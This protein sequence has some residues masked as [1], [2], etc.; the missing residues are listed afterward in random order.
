MNREMGEHV[1]EKSDTRG[2][3]M[4]ASSI[5]I[6]VYLYLRLIRLT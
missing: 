6:Q 4:S 1:I 3:L 2:N 5:Q